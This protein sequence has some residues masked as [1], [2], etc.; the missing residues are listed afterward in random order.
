MAWVHAAMPADTP[1]AD[2]DDPD[3]RLR[4]DWEDTPD[5]T[6]ADRAPGRRISSVPADRAWLAF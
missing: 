3:D 5:E 2:Q 4:P 6:D 1:F